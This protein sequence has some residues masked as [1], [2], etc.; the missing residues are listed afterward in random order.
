MLGTEGMLT[1]GQPAPNGK[2]QLEVDVDV[3]ADS[4]ALENYTQVRLCCGSW[5]ADSQAYVGRHQQYNK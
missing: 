2:L 1:E 4:Q 3:V 5:T